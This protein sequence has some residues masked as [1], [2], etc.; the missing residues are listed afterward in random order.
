MRKLTS[1]SHHL[2]GPKGI[3]AAAL[4]AAAV[5]GSTFGL[6]HRSS[7]Y[8]ILDQLGVS[9][10]ATKIA[11]A[12]I[13]LWPTTAS[14]PITESQAIQTC[15]IGWPIP[16]QSP[17]AAVYAHV[18]VTGFGWGPEGALDRDA[19]VFNIVPGSFQGPPGTEHVTLPTGQHPPLDSHHTVWALWF[20]GIPDPGGHP[21]WGIGTG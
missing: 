2:R 13:A 6:T 19:W 15:G 16:G 10:Y 18:H 9:D 17:K 8:D 12:G 20:E 4:V 7:A 5:G 1:F 14:P 11:G 21:C 3:V